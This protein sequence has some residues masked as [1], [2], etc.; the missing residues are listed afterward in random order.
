MLIAPLPRRIKQQDLTLRHLRLSDGPFLSKTLMRKDILI[1]NGILTRLGTSWIFFYWWLRRTFFVAYCIE[2]KSQPV[3]FIGLSN[4][5]V[6]KSSDISLV[7]FDPAFR[8][9]G[10]GTDAFKMLSRNSFTKA[11]ANTFIARVRKD[12]EPALCFWRKLGFE[13]L[14]SDNDIMVM[15]LRG[16]K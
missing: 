9:K 13:T 10:Y 11:F 7:L 12:N 2:H 6:G 1:S 4:L 8:R 14:R 3:G 16:D 15:E 5:M